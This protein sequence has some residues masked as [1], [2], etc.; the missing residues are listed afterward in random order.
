MDKVVKSS[1]PLREAK[2]P[3]IPVP[4]EGISQDEAVQDQ[5][6]PQ[7]P[8][9]LASTTTNDGPLI[10]K[11][12]PTVGDSI[13]SGSPMRSDEAAEPVLRRSN[14]DRKPPL[15]LRDYATS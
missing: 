4:K 14:R 10:G 1:L 3:M 2:I 6:V 8:N 9:D 13:P 7:V 15:K 11:C 12:P 5:S